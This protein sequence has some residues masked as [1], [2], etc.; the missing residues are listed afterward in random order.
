[1]KGLLRPRRGLQFLVRG[2]QRSISPLFTPRCRYLPTCSQ[3]AYEALG[4]YGA[5][6]GGWLAVRRLARCHPFHEGG[7]DPVPRK[8]S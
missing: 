3:Y 5:L 1:V 4:E 2:Y 6:G 8:V 7:Y